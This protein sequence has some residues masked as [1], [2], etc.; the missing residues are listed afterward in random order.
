GPG[1]E[2]L[3]SHLKSCMG[4]ETAGEGTISARA[5]HLDA[6]RRAETHTEEAVRQLT[7]AR[8]GELVAE[9]LRRA[10]QALNEITGDFHADDLLGRIFGSF[11]IGK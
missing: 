9:E 3:R 4:Y 2:S 7:V 5:R 10:Q 6:L 1:V 8:A 11:C